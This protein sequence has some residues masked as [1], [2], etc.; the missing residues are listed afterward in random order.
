[1]APSTP[2]APGWIAIDERTWRYDE[3]GVRFFLLTG[4]ERALLLDSGMTTHDARELAEQLTDLPLALCNTHCDPDHI[5]SDAEFDEVWLSP[6]EL[7]HPLAP[8]D[9][10]V[11]RPL[12][13]GDVL[14]LGE[15]PLE[16]IALPGHTPG[17]I[18]LLD[19]T[20]G[21]LFSGDPIQRDGRI[22][23]FGPM[24]SL[25][26]YI[27]S[28]Q[29]LEMRA[30]EISSIW[31]CHAACPIGTDAIGELI[32]GAQAVERG[33]VPYAEEEV[34]GTP[35]RAYDVGVSVLLCND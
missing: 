4:S 15:R 27:H 30:D 12:W 22:Y 20:T 25:A 2:K 8:H 1:M 7:V 35:I 33:E 26:A 3:Q 11:V 23:M 5:G 18:A 9:S 32:A 19:R 21:M 16:V 24:R 13:D 10:R 29:R 14:D 34:H 28:L 6:C 17:S 31:P